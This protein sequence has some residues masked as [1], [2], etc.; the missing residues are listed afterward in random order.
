M[1]KVFLATAISYVIGQQINNLIKSILDN[2][3]QLM[4]EADYNNDNQD[5]FKPMRMGYKSW[6]IQIQKIIY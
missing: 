1:K 5:D 2:V 3:I 4:M 6:T